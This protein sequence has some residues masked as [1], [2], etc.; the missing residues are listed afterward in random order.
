MTQI[1]RVVGL[2]GDFSR[3]PP[4]VLSAAWDR[5][6]AVH[7]AIAAHHYEYDF[8]LAP[9][10]K[11]WVDAYLRFAEESK[12]VPTVSEGYVRHDAWG[13]CG[14]LDRIGWVTLEGFTGHRTV[15]DFKSGG[16]EAVDLQLAGYAAAWNAMH[17]KEPIDRSAAVALRKDGTYRFI[18]FDLRAAI[19][20]W[21]ATVTVYRRLMRARGGKQ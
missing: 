3:I 18:P 19:P 15:L 12:H 13:Y 11:P 17:V 10:W 7:E 2:S 14:R 20:E 9:E 8:D 4:D 1:L 5:G 16:A 21:Y 6:S